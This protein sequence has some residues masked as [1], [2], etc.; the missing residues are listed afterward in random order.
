M[1]GYTIKTDVG[2]ETPGSLSSY[3]GVDLGIP[4]ITLELPSYNPDEAWQENRD[5]LIAAINF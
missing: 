3:T 1:N 5:A 2:Y 4:T